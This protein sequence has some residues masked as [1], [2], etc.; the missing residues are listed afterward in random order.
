MIREQK[1]SLFQCLTSVPSRAVG[2]E[3]VVRL[4]RYDSSVEGRTQSYRKMAAVLGKEKADEEV[5]RKLMPAVSLGRAFVDLGFERRTF[6]N[7]R[8]YVV[9]RRSL[10]EMR[11][12]RQA[13][14]SCPS[15]TDTDVTDVF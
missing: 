7:V 1:L 4:I 11:S 8:G 9:V 12:I 15:D 14:A 6:R 5:K 13:M 10:E 3:E 2:L